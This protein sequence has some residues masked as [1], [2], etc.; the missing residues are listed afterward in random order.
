M[1]KTSKGVFPFRDWR[2]YMKISTT[3][4]ARLELGQNLKQ[5]LGAENCPKVNTSSEIAAAFEGIVGSSQ[6]IMIAGAIDC[7][8]RLAHWSVIAMGSNDRMTVRPGDAF[9]GA[10]QTCASGIFLIHN[11]PSGSLEASKEDFSFTNNVAEAGIIFGYP[12]L[13]H[14]IVSKNGFRSLMTNVVLKSRRNKVPA[15]VG[16][17]CEAPSEMSAK[18]RWVCPQCNKENSGR[19]SDGIQNHDS[20]MARAVRC[21]ACARLSWLKGNRGK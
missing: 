10:I 12:L 7:K 6:E 16:Y 18:L 15:A 14:V 9:L 11:H 21:A 13:D 2:T 17:V 5:V 19:W 20:G 3:F 1:K 8:C 4:R